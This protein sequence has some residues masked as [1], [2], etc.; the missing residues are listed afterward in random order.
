M[1]RVMLEHLNEIESKSSGLTK[2]QHVCYACSVCQRQL[3]TFKAEA[4]YATERESLGR[5]LDQVWAWLED[6]TDK[7]FRGNFS[8]DLFLDSYGLMSYGQGFGD[9]IYSV[10]TL[11]N[12][13]VKNLDIPT[14]LVSSHA[15]DSLDSLVYE[16]MDLTVSN[17]N[18]DLVDQHPL[19]QREFIRQKRDLSVV[20]DKE[21]SGESVQLLK[22]AAKHEQLVDVCPLPDF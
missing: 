8:I 18:D 11:H 15:L 10:A 20:C 13:L 17:V 12:F 6:E 4:K 14:K 9:V 7:V 3:S 2:M 22:A 19:I 1:A 16:L 21:L 5:Y